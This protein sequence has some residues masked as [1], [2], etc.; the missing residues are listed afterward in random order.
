MIVDKSRLDFE[1][2]YLIEHPRFRIARDGRVPNIPSTD[3]GEWH[4]VK[5][6]PA[7]LTLALSP[8]YPT[9]ETFSTPSE[10]NKIRKKIVIRDYVGTSAEFPIQD[11]D[12]VNRFVEDGVIMHYSGQQGLRTYHTHLNIHGLMYFKQSLLYYENKD[13]RRPNIKDEQEPTIRSYEVFCRIF[14]IIESGS[15]FYRYVGYSG[16]LY[17]RM[18]FENLIGVQFWD[19]YFDGDRLANIIKYSVDPEIDV[20]QIIA[21]NGLMIRKME[22]AQ[23][24][25]QRIGWAFNSDITNIFVKKFYDYIV[26]H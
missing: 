17:F 6:Q 10:L 18:R 25:M 23:Y 2:G 15:I 13:I 9:T 20:N 3:E 4:G 24:F 22:I 11:H 26:S 21:A 7:L 19:S 1:I 14:E 16:P 12:S 8:L 5:E